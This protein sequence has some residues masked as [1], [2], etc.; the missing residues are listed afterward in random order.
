LYSAKVLEESRRADE[1]I[2]GK[3]SS[4]KGGWL[5]INYC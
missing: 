1:D 4:W 5:R 2:L 3:M